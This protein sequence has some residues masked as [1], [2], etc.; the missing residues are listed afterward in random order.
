MSSANRD[1]ITTSLKQQTYSGKLDGVESEI[2]ERVM[3]AWQ[4][5]GYFKAQ[6]HTDARV[7]TS[8]PDNERTAVTVQVDEGQQYRLEQIRFGNNKAIGNV[9]ALRKLF[10]IKDGDVFDRAAI[11]KG[12]ENLRLAYGQLGY[13][14]LTS[15]PDTRFSE[16]HQTISLGI[17]LDEGKRFLVSRIDIIGLDESGFKNV[18][19]EI[20]VTPGDLYNQRLVDLFLQHSASLL[21]PEA[22]PEPRFNPQLN[23][24]AA[25]VAIRYDFRRCPVD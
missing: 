10:P 20:F 2:S 23:K 5:S 24:S 21:P 11:G 15:V 7:L 4:S 16:E 12:L 17:D 6:V 1:Q 25:T 19:K 3:A 18:L 13:I 14:N 9:E 22:A 8:S